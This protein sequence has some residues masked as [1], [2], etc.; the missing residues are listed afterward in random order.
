MS[1]R[2]N[3]DRQIKI[4]PN[5]FEYAKKKIESLGFKVTVLDEHCFEFMFN[6]KKVK[7]WPYSG[8]ATGQTITDGRGLSKLIRQLTII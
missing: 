1:K 4:E 3:I 8:W 5:R 7:F 6:N 2:L